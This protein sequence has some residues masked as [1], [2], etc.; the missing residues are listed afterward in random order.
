MTI[1]QISVFVENKPGRLSEVTGYLADANINIHALSIADT[2]DFGILRLIVSDVE[3]ARDVLKER[4]LAVK[5]T[6]VVG[7]SLKHRPGGLHEVLCEMDKARIAIEYM[8]AF[9]SRVET[10][11]AIVVLCL[12]DQEASLEKLK[13]Y[14]IPFVGGDVVQR[15][16]QA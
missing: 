14:D 1:D 10:C 11:D 16:N 13:E 6:D 4:G 15:M 8:Y 5:T 3:K 12:A 9:T 2:T 7:V